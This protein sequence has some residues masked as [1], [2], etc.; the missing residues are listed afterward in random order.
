L[1]AFQLIGLSM[2]SHVIRIVILIHILF[3][4]G[5]AAR[6]IVLD[7]A[8]VRNDTARIIT[9][10]KVLHEPTGKAGAVN[11]IM[12]QSTFELGFA[13]APMRGKRAIITWRDYEGRQR[14]VELSLPRG[15]ATGERR[16]M[17][18]LIY[19]IHPSGEVTVELE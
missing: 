8:V 17:M 12:P 15:P 14:G 2:T 18:S 10:V 13:G 1:I 11:M 19:T 4:S 16:D 3:L 7:R 6:H 9:E 5:C